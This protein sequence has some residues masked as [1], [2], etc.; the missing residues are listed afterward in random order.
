MISV[1][2][3]CSG[4]ALTDPITQSTAQLFRGLTNSLIITSSLNLNS[5]PFPDTDSSAIS[6]NCGVKRKQGNA[7]H[8]L[9]GNLNSGSADGPGSAMYE[10]CLPRLGLRAQ[11]ERLVRREEGN[12]QGGALNSRRTYANKY[13][14]RNV[15]L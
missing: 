9:P 4:K 6:S 3:I 13:Q 7:T 10:D 12:T 1:P 5:I 8:S 14:K 2:Q 15:A 11:D